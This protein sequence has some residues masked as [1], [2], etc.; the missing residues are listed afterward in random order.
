MVCKSCVP[1]LSEVL[2]F[3]EGCRRAMAASFALAH[4]MGR[5]Q[6]ET[7]AGTCPQPCSCGILG[8]FPPRMPQLQAICGTLISGS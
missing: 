4:R 3:S 1:R 6:T 5:L 7:C 8:G 2:L